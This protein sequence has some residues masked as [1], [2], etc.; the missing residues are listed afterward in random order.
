MVFYLEG[1]VGL[2]CRKNVRKIHTKTPAISM[3]S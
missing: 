3:K 2:I 1:C